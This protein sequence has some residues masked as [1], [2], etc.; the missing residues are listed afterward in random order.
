MEVGCRHTSG[1]GN[2]PQSCSAKPL[3]LFAADAAMDQQGG[4][5]DL[6]RRSRFVDILPIADT[7]GGKPPNKLAPSFFPCFP[8]FPSLQA[9]CSRVWK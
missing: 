7:G 9:I 5:A 4:A 6:G 2:P 3:T 8:V 1:G